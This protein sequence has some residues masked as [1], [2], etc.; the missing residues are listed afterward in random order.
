MRRVASVA[1]AIVMAATLIA[2]VSAAP[3]KIGN[4]GGEAL[5]IEGQHSFNLFD[6]D[7][8]PQWRLPRGGVPWPLSEL[9]KPAK[10]ETS[11]PTEA[12]IEE[13][14]F[15]YFFGSDVWPHWAFA[16]AGVLWSPAGLS[17]EG[18][19]LKV[20]ING[21][22]YR[23]I[24]GALNDTTILGQ[25]S[26]ITAMPGWR[27][28]RAGFEFTIFAG[29]DYQQFRFTPDDPDTRLRG[30]HFGLRAGF[31][32]WHEP[33]PATMLTADASISSIGAG[34]Y[35][36]IAYGWR[37]FDRFYLGPEAQIYATDP[38]VH[39]R[40]GTVLWRKRHLNVLG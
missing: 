10:V 20:L 38:Y 22:A 5:H 7:L 6:S 25:Q 39:G 12:H 16:H 14:H 26:S 15:L 1:V 11:G 27:F 3:A 30:R 17:N 8:W 28:K 18:F 29:F 4:D 35:A 34:S 2:G 21:G 31:E 24:S 23:Y 19:T 33:S 32:L 9:G 36:R 40:V 37:L 13:Q